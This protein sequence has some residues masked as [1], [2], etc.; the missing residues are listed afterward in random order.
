MRKK[1]SDAELLGDIEAY[2]SIDDSDE[3]NPEL[4]LDSLEHAITN[5]F[6]FR[7][8][9]QF[10]EREIPRYANFYDFTRRGLNVKAFPRQLQVIMHA[11]GEICMFCSDHDWAYGMFDQDMQDIQRK[12]A[13]MR[14]GRCPKC[15]RTRLDMIKHNLWYFPNRIAL[16]VGQRG[17]KNMTLAMASLYQ[18]HLFLTL[19][20]DKQ[21][22]SPYEYFN[23]MPTFVR[24]A[25]TGV[26]AAQAFDNIWDQIVS[27]RKNSPWY[28]QYFEFLKYHGQRLGQELYKVSDT[29]VSYHHKRMGVTIKTPDK[30]KLRGA[31]RYFCGIDEIC[32]FNSSMTEAQEKKVGDV[33]EVWVSLNNS[34]RTLRNSAD[35]LMR[36][37]VYDVP[38]SFTMDISSPF[39]INDILSQHLM[40]AKVNK[41]IVAG[42]YATWEF[43]PNYTQ[44]SLA[45]EFIKDAEIAWRD[46]GAIPPLAN[47]P[48]MGDAKAVI[49]CV[50]QTPDPTYVTY[51]VQT[52]RNE[53]F[54]DVTTWLELDRVNFNNAAHVIAIDNGLSN[55]AFG[56]SVASLEPGNKC[57][58]DVSFMLKPPAG[59][60]INL[61][62]MYT[63]FIEP[64]VKRSNC[65]AVIYDHWNSI[66]NVQNLRDQKYDARQYT[67][68]A[69]DFEA[70]KAS[71][72][73]QTMS[74]PF[75]EYPLNSLL[76]RSSEV[77]LVQTAQDK[78][79]FSLVLQ[80]LTVREIGGG[81]VVKP[82]YGDD[83]VF[84]TA[85]LCHRFVMDPEIQIALMRGGMN[86]SS[87][88]AS[89]RS[90]GCVRTA[91]QGYGSPKGGFLSYKPSTRIVQQPRRK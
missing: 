6:D 44:E 21:R 26:T 35:Q 12:V 48:W 17:G 78:P 31:T 39:D 42:H 25:F 68:T 59:A 61:D 85:A 11:H 28:N 52:G 77:D 57:R 34:L 81:K 2:R 62:K 33:K 89:T 50:R 32:W 88:K 22:V 4:L 23:L 80:T 76:T 13:F 14:F 41:R 47:S 56:C 18:D 51:R 79:H 43:N 82:K 53:T 49:E 8:G 27:V 46:F 86:A 9:T 30:R 87:V 90:V 73:S 64:L 37:G 65:V 10:D 5:D 60:K 67:L 55:N 54:N 20:K 38:N 24:Q 36:A 72:F 3:F 45:E 69:K 84:R 63:E 58:I 74:Y 70:I 19:E 16:L 7:V 40:E 66:Q 91:S 29:F 15:K 1:K 71:F 75:T 83:D